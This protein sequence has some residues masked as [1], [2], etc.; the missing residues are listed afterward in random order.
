MIRRFL[1]AVAV[2]CVAAGAW[3]HDGRDFSITLDDHEDCSGRHIRFSGEPAFVKEEVVQAANLRSIRVSH[4]PLTVRGGSGSGYSITVCKAAAV[5]ADLNDIDVSVDGGALKSSGPSHR[6][7]AVM[8]VVRAPRGAN[9][10]V[11]AENGPVSVRDFSGDLKVDM[12]NGP[13]SLDDVSGDIDVSTTNGPI[14]LAGGSG[15]VKVSAANGPLSVKLEGRGWDGQLEAS[16]RNGPLTVRVPRNYGSGVVV[17][18]NGHGP[19]SC[20]VEDCWSVNARAERWD[21]RPR[22]FEFG[23]G[24][25]NVHISTVN[26]PLTIKEAD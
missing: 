11:E 18:T 13:L 2:T 17:E 19:V 12:Q 24:Q 3:A 16:T 26:G 20:R 6:R 4:S 5:A 21:D 9:L 7:W 25:Q 22:R 15:N 10:D 1:L 8:Y 14:S 23:R